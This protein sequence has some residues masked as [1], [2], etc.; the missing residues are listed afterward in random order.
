MAHYNLNV[1]GFEVSFKAEADPKR[2]EQAKHLLEERY[3]ALRQ[4]GKQLSK[5]KLLTF[6]AL[7]LADDML[8]AREEME[9]SEKRLRT[10]VDTLN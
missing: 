1:L 2:I 6:L 10:L 3:D 4:H 8:Q 7:A 5:E 9:K